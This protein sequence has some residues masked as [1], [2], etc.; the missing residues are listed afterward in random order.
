MITNYDDSVEKLQDIGDFP[1]ECDFD[2]W[3]EDFIVF[4]THEG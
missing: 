1:E 3:V 2:E 4:L